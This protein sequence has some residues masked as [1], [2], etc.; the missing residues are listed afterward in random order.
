MERSAV[1]VVANLI[2]LAKKAGLRRRTCDA[3]QNRVKKFTR[4]RERNLL[5]DL[6]QKSSDK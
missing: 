1:V 5:L 3:G 4:E 6:L 2:V